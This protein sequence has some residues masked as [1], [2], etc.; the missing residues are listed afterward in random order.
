M[1]IDK[2][3]SFTRFIFEPFG[4]FDCVTWSSWKCT[5]ALRLL[6]YLKHVVFSIWSL[7]N[8]ESTHWL[9]SISQSTVHAVWIYSMNSPFK[10]T[11]PNNAPSEKMCSG[12][13]LHTSPNLQSSLL[14]EG[15]LGLF[16]CNMQISDVTGH[17][18]YASPNTKYPSCIAFLSYSG[19]RSLNWIM[20]SMLMSF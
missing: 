14:L 18:K 3:V 13:S 9:V 1:K 11:S 17:F 8:I 5:V 12:T 7:R 19:F 2:A 20:T 15:V 4:A 16:Q 10:T 6:C